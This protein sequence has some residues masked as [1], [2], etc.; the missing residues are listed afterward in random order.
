MAVDDVDPGSVLGFVHTGPLRDADLDPAGRAEIFS[1]YVDPDAWR[2]GIGSALL[3]AV[4]AF[5]KPAGTRELSLWVFED[6][7]EARAFYERLGW[8]DDGGR[9]TAEFGGVYPVERRYRR[10]LAL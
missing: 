8:A 9:Q 6:N 1:I 4:E 5:W 10:R 7:R 2:Q 3:D